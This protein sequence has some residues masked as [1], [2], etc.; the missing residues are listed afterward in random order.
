MYRYE[1]CDVLTKTVVRNVQ[2]MFDEYIL[3]YLYVLVAPK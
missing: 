1:S 2:R 3:S